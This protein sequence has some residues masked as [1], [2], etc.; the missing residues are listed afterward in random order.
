MR[1]FWGVF[2]SILAYRPSRVCI[3]SLLSGGNSGE[4]LVPGREPE[5]IAMRSFAPAFPCGQKGRY[6]AG[7]GIA[8][9]RHL[10]R[11]LCILDHL[12]VEDP[13]AGETEAI[14]AL[15]FHV[16]DN[17]G[18]SLGFPHQLALARPPVGADRT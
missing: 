7:C 9:H 14:P 17:L 11:V 18:R 2:P 16:R 1:W 3:P 13:F 6:H 10:G 15:V 5:R 8:F 4:A 12:R